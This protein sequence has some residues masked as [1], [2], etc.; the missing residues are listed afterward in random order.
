M[1]MT[2]KTI[3]NGDGK[4]T[5][6]FTLLLDSISYDLFE[7]LFPKQ[8]HH[9]HKYKSRLIIPDKNLCKALKLSSNEQKIVKSIKVRIG[10]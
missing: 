1:R 4:S 9:Q 7:V 6:C 5:S 2:M 3:N 8:I 10:K